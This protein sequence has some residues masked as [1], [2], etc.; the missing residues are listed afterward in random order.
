MSDIWSDHSSN[1]I[2][3]VREQRRLWPDIFCQLPVNDCEQGTSQYFHT[4]YYAMLHLE[5]S[6]QYH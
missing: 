4:D 5:L 3:H 6:F 2:L 1:F